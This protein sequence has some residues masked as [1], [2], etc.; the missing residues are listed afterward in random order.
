MPVI[1][2]LGAGAD[3]DG[4]APL[5]P[6]AVRFVAPKDVD[7]D[8]FL[9]RAFVPPNK[10][11]VRLVLPGA[12][13]V[14]V[15]ESRRTTSTV[16]LRVARRATRFLLNLDA[17]VVATAQENSKDWFA[18]QMNPSLIEEYY[19]GSCAADRE[20]GLLA[21]LVL[22][23]HA[24]PECQ[25]G[26][27]LDVEVQLVGIQFRRQY[28]TAAWKAVAVRA[29]PQRAFVFVEDDDGASSAAGDGDGG[30]STSASDRED[31]SL[32][33]ER[34]S[35]REDMLERIRAGVAALERRADELRS[36]AA[37]LEAAPPGDIASLEAAA[38]RLDGQLT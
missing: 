33:D 32:Y 2:N 4:S 9:C 7:S 22:D 34:V 36:L 3:A 23:G 1:V 13:V 11:A 8:T 38:E 21:K 26:A 37:A 27:R 19:H 31:D 15:S 5:E 12:V 17:H 24:P 25:P 29:P 14:R 20:H 28:F 10:Q 35:I 6:T 18:V 16:Y 30:G